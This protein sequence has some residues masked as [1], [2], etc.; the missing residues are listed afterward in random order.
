VTVAPDKQS[1]VANLTA[2]GNVPGDKDLLVQEMKFKLKK[3][4][5][6][7]Y[8]QRIETVKTLSNRN[9]NL[10]PP[11]SREQTSNIQHPTTRET[12]NTNSQSGGRV[13]KRFL[14][15]FQI[16]ARRRVP[17]LDV[18]VWHFSGGWMLDVGCLH[19]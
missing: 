10:Q 9:S 18:G 14:N 5:R 1:A 16:H 12:A 8:I 11:T 6:S 13:S 7:W 2:K 4:G 15:Q 17:S 3:V 19:T